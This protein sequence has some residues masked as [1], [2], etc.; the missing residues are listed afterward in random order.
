MF[1]NFKNLAGL[2]G[3]M[4]KAKEMQGKMQEVQAQLGDL[5]ADADAGAGMVTA[6]CNGK[7]ELVKLRIDP[8]RLDLSKARAEDLEM[9]E[10]LVVAA[11][12][13][14][15]KKSAELAREQMAKVAE[16]MGLP[17]GMMDQLPGGMGG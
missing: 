8:E 1:D 6:T 12:A 11:V 14:A 4:Q 2:P 17:P 3:M 9:L 16:E 10:D 15:Q 13:A 5:R 7:M